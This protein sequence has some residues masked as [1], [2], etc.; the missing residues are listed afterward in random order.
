MWFGGNGLLRYDGYNFKTFKYNPDDEKSLSYNGVI[1]IFEDRSGFL[2]IGTEGGGLNKYN[3]ETDKFTRY[4]HDPNDSKSLSNN[5]VF[6]ILQDRSGNLWF[7]TNGG[8]L[9][10]LITD[11]SVTSFIHYKNDPNEPTSLSSDVVGKICEDKSG[12]LWIATDYGLNKLVPGEMNKLKPTFIR[13]RHNSEDP[14]SLS[15]DGV[16]SIFGDNSGTLWIGTIGGGLNKLIPGDSEESTPSFIHYS[17]D[18]ND[19]TSIS[20]NVVGSIYEDGSGNL[21]VGTWGGGLNKFNRVNQ[22]FTHYK[23]NPND[24]KSLNGNWV[25]SIYEDNSGILWV[26]TMPG[27]LNKFDPLKNQFKLYKVNPKDP[28]SLSSDRVFSIYE[29]SDGILW[30]GTYYGGLNRLLPDDGKKS[31]PSF[32]RYSHN[33]NDPKSINSVFS[34][35]EDNSGNIWLGTLDG[36][37]YELIKSEKKESNPKF[38]HYEFDPNDPTSLSNNSIRV[39]FKDKGGNLWFGT[40]N[41]LNKLISGTDEMP[42][43]T[44]VRYLNNPQ[45]PASISNNQVWCIYQ[46]KQETIW[47]GTSEGLN[48]LI[49]PNNK[50]SHA[51]FIHFTHDSRN[52]SSISGNQVISMFE[53]NL[54]NFWI[55]TEGG[56]LNKFD[57]KNGQFIH[58]KVEDGLPDNS[59]SGILGDNEGNLWVSTS[60]GLS[61]FN[62][63]TK[64]FKNY[65][66]KDGLQSSLFS[67]RGLF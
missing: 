49:P 15:H 58:F 11:D 34:I 38:V 47:I 33:L 42:S 32:F 65:S 13:Y 22:K 17:N 4:M 1:S 59:V 25:Y 51:T 18:P 48:K 35:C 29:D 40:D 43:A 8:G 52:P 24:S 46:D 61:K 53:D 23:F 16:F 36:G 31:T 45:D 28:K 57:R 66:T 37:V 12:N 50:H 5:T 21:W 62:P 55:G 41:G 56:G 30:I 10:K 14:N 19:P 60:N 7:G 3:R 27:G 2:W 54:G 63:K 64:T 26:G 44:F 9:N 20:S 67:G 6:G 39:I